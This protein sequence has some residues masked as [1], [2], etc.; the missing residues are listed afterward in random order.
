MYDDAQRRWSDETDDVELPPPAARR[1]PRGLAVLDALAMTAAI[2]YAGTL[3]ARWWMPDVRGWTRVAL[4]AAGAVAV[5]A[6]LVV[7]VRWR[8]RADARRQGAPLPVLRAWIATVAAAVAVLLVAGALPQ[9]R[10][11]AQARRLAAEAARPRTWPA[12]AVDGYTFELTTRYVDDSIPYTLTVRC[13]AD[14]ICPPSR[15]LSLSLH[16]P[17]GDPW[18]VVTPS[19]LVRGDR[20]VWRARRSIRAGGWFG[21]GE[22]LRTETWYLYIP[23]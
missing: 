15:N 7:W 4:Y 16:A 11:N 9:R 13:P 21:P 1:K 14:R 2:I 10:M 3:P 19:D 5:F 12:R 6:L 18:D 8:E 22:Y 23:G 20:R 17:A